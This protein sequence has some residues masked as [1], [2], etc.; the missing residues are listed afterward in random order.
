V[1]LLLDEQ[2]APDIAEQLRRDGRDVIAVLEQPGL[3][4]TDDESLLAWAAT[5]QRAL[6]TNNVRDFAPIA[7]HWTAA[8]QA[9]YGLIFVSDKTLPRSRNT[10]GSLA[11]T[12]RKLLDVHP[13]DDALQNQIRWLV[14]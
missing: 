6:V 4:S 7:Q 8:G 5:E 12:L 1:K 9:H 11:R 14:P 2:Y 3:A 13:G 10:S